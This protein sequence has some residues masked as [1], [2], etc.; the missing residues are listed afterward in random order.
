MKNLFLLALL[1]PLFAF[2]QYQVS[3]KV[4]DSKSKK[5]LVFANVIV[6]KTIGTLTDIDGL[7]QISSTKPIS[8]ITISYVGYSTKIIVLNNSKRF[9][10][11]AL[12]ASVENLKEVLI[13]AKENPALQIIRNA[14]KNRE[15]NNIETGLNTFKFKAYNKILV[16]A[17]PDSIDGKVDSIFKIKK[18]KKSFFKLDSS[19]YKFHKEIKNKH[20]YISEKIS[21]FK[22]QKGK[23]KKEVILAS[24]MAGLQQPIYELLA[25]TLQDFSIYNPFY[26]VAGTKYNNPIADHALK[27]YAYKILD[28]VNNSVGKSVLVYFK[29]KQSKKVLGIEGVLYIDQKSFAITKAIFELKGIVHVKAT[30]NFVYKKIAKIWFPSSKEILIKKGVNKKQIL[31]FGGMVKFSEAVKNDS[32]QNTKKN[33]AEAITY[34]LSKTKNF[35]IEINS[36]VNVKKSSSTILFVNDAAHK[37]EKFWNTYRTDSITNR[38]KKTYLVLDSLAKTEHIERKINLARSILKGFYPTKYIDLNL[39]KI[40]NLNNYEGLRLGF[41]GITNNQFSSKFKL[42]SYIA[43]GTKDANFKYNFG[44]SVLL[45][46]ETNTWLSTNYTN[47][48]KEAAS[49]DFIAENTSFSPVNPRNL[50]I[51]KFYNYKT[52]SVGIKHDIQPNFETKIQLSTGDYKPVFNYQFISSNK[53]LNKYQLTLATIGFQY[54][55][56][57]EYMN[58]PIGKLTIKNEFP[59]FTFQIAKSFENVF[60][61]DFNFTQINLRIIENVKPLKSGTTKILIEGGIVLGDTPISHLFNSAPNYTFKNPW[62]RRINLAGTNSFETMGYNEFISDRFAA[63]HIKHLLKPL[64]LFKKFR[65][66]FTLVTRA[67][68][69]NINNPSFQTGIQFKSLK[70]GY[71]ESGLELNSLF[72][73]FGLSAEYRYGAYTNPIWSDNL[74]VK[75]TFKL[76]L[77]I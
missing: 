15:K 65:P 58:S 19:N 72:K 67:V 54:N 45:N 8:E 70:K 1:F 7:F 76:N 9:R 23:K 31:L 26:T 63:I 16:T 18:N 74:A 39:G 37:S 47:D 66:Q 48:I 25:I 5:P 57:S 38:D 36:P 52:I 44:T 73:G 24:R 71:F 12:K 61:S 60:Q 69:G 41:G 13:T 10:T 50:N 30:Q 6:T 17:N 55:P 21:E 35:N 14:I 34:F 32:I 62:R 49:L 53:N 51:S 3:G 28:T 4:I 27:H 2:S 40:I 11:I 59:Q 75:L 64:K 43:Y 22:F 20:L 56:K 68:I 29:P 46:N 33:G 42:E 77:G